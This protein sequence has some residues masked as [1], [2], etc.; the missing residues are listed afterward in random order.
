[1]EE[2]L[3]ARYAR[4]AIVSEALCAGLSLLGLRRHVEA[5]FALPQLTTVIVPQALDEGLIR[6]NLLQ[7]F[8]I[9]IGAGLGELSGRVWRIGLMGET[10]QPS[11]V[12][13]LLLAL[14]Q[15]LE[16]MEGNKEAYKALEAAELVLNRL[17]S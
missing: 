2:G 4:H 10:A 15:I 11:S 5:Q 7:R 13:S 17:K 8:N 12:R 16:E 9:E 3:E 14:G 1:L 6:R